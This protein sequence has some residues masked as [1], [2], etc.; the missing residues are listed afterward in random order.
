LAATIQPV[1]LGVL[2]LLQAHLPA[3][4]GQL[5]A[6]A[7]GRGFGRFC[8]PGLGLVVKGRRLCSRMFSL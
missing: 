2:A 8:Q 1:A 3:A 7:P 6:D 4:A 5:L